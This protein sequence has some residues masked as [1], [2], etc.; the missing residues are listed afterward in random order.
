MLSGNGRLRLT[1]EGVREDKHRELVL[2]LIAPGITAWAAADLAVLTV[3]DFS[4]PAFS[5]G[6]GLHD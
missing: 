4:Q 3:R 5:G 1:P 2:S 6:A